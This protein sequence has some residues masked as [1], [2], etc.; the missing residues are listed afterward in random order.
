MPV[1]DQHVGPESARLEVPIDPVLKAKLRAAARTQR[2]SM[3][4]ATRA[5]IEAFVAAAERAARL[6]DEAEAPEG[7][8]ASSRLAIPMHAHAD[9]RIPGG[10]EDE[11]VPGG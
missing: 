10:G 11:R 5:A 2:L 9:P 8:S 7:T 1:T 6:N 3:S 4:A